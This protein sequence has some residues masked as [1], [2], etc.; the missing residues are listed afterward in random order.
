MDADLEA[1]T[2]ASTT[3]AAETTPTANRVVD[4]RNLTPVLSRENVLEAFGSLNA[5]ASLILINDTDPQP[6]R[7]HLEAQ[8][9]GRFLWE[10]VESGPPTWQ[11]RLGRIVA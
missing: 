10:E 9:S 6:L 4:L 11:I 1:G 2:P 7:D 5:S 8:E 3:A